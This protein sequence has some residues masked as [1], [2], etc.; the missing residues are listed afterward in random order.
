[1]FCWLGS[2]FAPCFLMAFFL[3][4][5]FS[6]RLRLRKRESA[7]HAVGRRKGVKSE[8]LPRF[9]INLLLFTGISLGKGRRKGWLGGA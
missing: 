2:T 7:R 6:L 4:F 5:Y 3:L 8:A 1:M 9:S